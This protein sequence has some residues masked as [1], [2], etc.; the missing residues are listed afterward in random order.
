[1]LS[2]TNFNINKN[3]FNNIISDSCQTKPGRRTLASTNVPLTVVDAT[4]PTSSSSSS[5]SS[6]HLQVPGASRHPSS[7]AI[8]G[9]GGVKQTNTNDDNVD[10]S[11]RK[12]FDVRVR[13]VNGQSLIHISESRFNIIPCF[14]CSFSF[15]V[16]HH[17]PRCR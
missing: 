5:S 6:Q 4:L 15:L 8:G 3:H 10:D 9:G 7:A 13:L 1:L 16:S 12:I 11:E 2:H 17:R 14:V